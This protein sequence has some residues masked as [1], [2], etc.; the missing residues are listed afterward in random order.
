MVVTHPHNHAV[1]NH[2]TNDL[3]WNTDPVGE[4]LK[5]LRFHVEVRNA[6][7]LARGEELLLLRSVKCAEEAIA[8]SLIFV[9]PV[10]RH[11]GSRDAVHVV[12]L[13]YIENLLEHLLHTGTGIVL[14]FAHR[15]L[16][17]ERVH[18]LIYRKSGKNQLSGLDA[19]ASAR[20]ASEEVTLGQR[21]RI[22]QRLAHFVYDDLERRHSDSVTHRENRTRLVAS[23]HTVPTRLTAHTDRF[24][25]WVPS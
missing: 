1:H 4:G 7:V 5:E 6:S 9:E 17:V 13:C 11:R 3:S 14:L 2:G 8:A 10:R 21:S 24:F 12:G 15:L 23:D 19:N 25:Q 16:D 18:V 20:P 22:A